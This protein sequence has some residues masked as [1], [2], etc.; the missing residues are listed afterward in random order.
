MLCLFESQNNVIC[1]SDLEFINN[2]LK[3]LKGLFLIFRLL[4]STQYL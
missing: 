3:G 4:S 2:A 1:M